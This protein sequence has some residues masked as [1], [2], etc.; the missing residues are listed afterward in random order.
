MIYD[1]EKNVPEISTDSWVAPNAIIIG[2]VKLE[3][4]SSIWFNA[5]LRGDIE[6]IVIGEDSNIQDGSVLHTDPGC[7]LTVGKGVTVGHMVML[8]GC[9]ISDDTLIGIGSTILNKAKIGK[10]CIIGANT[11]VTENKTIPDNSLV[12]GSPGKVIRKVTDDEIKVI[13][14]NAKHYVKN[15]KRYK[16]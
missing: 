5:V 7:P 2:K 3:K 4:N 15:S 13:R 12:L 6:K 10:N 14:E 11:L 16:I 1:L 8:H 9:E